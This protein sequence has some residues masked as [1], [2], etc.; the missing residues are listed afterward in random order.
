MSKL[1]LRARIAWLLAGLASAALAP[2]DAFAQDELLRPGEGFVTRFSGAEPGPT[3][4]LVIDLDGT[5]GSIIDLRNP[6]R[7]PQGQHWIDEPQ[8]KPV[9]AAQVGQVFGVVLDDANP[10][11]IYLASTSAFGLHRTPDNAQ[12]MPGMWGPA[13]PGA[14]YRLDAATGYAPRPFAQ[15]TFGNRPNSGPALG[16][17]A[18]DRHHRQLF[19]SDLETGM[20]HRFRATDGAPLGMFDHG[21]QGRAN[22]RDV[23]S[24]QPRSLPPIA[25]DPASQARITNCPSKFDTSPQCWNFAASGRRV[26]GLGVHR[27]PGRNEV[28][29]YYSV[30]SGPAFGN[31]AWNQASD[32]DKRNSVWSV[33]LAPDGG[34]DLSDVRREFLLPDFFNRPEDIARAGYSQPVSDITFSACGPRPVMLLAERGGI[35][36]LGLGSE[37]SFSNPHEARALRYELDQAGA[38]RAVGRYDVGFYDRKNEGQP[39]LRANCSGGIAFGLGYD[40]NWIADPNKPDQFVWITGHALC[41][42]LGPCN[43]PAFDAAGA[44][45]AGSG[46]QFQAQP[47]VPPGMPAGGQVPAQP[48]MPMEVDP[49]TQPDD[50]QVHG[51]QGL[52]ETAFEE[53]ATAAAFAPYPPQGEPTV[54]T[55][56]NQAYLIDTDINVDASGGLIEQELLR[57]DATKI[58]DIAIYEICQAPAAYAATYLL[59]PPVFGVAPPPLIG[60]ALEVSHALVASHGRESSHYRF[61]SH[62]PYWSHNRWGSHNTYWS[63]NR[64]GS[65]NLVW[66]HNR[67]GSHLRQLSHNRQGS[68]TRAISHWRIGSHDVQFSHRRLGS[69]NEQ[70]S[71]SRTGSHNERISHQRLGSHNL[72][73]SHQRL[74][75]HNQSLSHSNTGSHNLQLSHQRLGSHTTALSHV[76]TGSH[77]ADRSHN[78]LGSHNPVQSHNRIGSGI[79]RPH[80]P[81]A[82]HNQTG[83]HSVAQSGVHSQAVSSLRVP[84]TGPHSTQAS[85]ARVG[86]QVHSTALS[87]NIT[88]PGPGAHNQAASHARVGSHSRSVSQIQ[89][90]PG[91]HLRAQSAAVNAPKIKIQPQQF[92]QQQIQQQQKKQTSS[93]SSGPQRRTHDSR[94]SRAQQN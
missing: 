48:G 68:H 79:T 78:V 19:A 43:M 74:G 93:G 87:K 64:Q 80:D 17:L 50:S 18:Y 23:E 73:L 7:P 54:A 36:N 61:G 11:N 22:F 82:S 77:A 81:K 69:H 55:G 5:V 38:W 94:A 72:V 14:I 52:A 76:R 59:P 35:R 34:F 6:G 13:G 31:V 20:I 66:S 70:I 44:P 28:R 86:S 32:D 57:N 12:W 67:L 91:G 62:N 2:C 39:F 33:R 75:S 26:W 30:W 90:A 1:P 51:L 63:H 9:T 89:V 37:N 24:G 46:G 49:N 60:H 65:H 10:P 45:T 15:V 53:I 25:F 47:G 42:P 84:G 40:P 29:L 83:S 92:Q 27:D 16:N 8:R 41:S 56:P 58:G 3:G 4:A 88:G 71:H 21:L 85:H